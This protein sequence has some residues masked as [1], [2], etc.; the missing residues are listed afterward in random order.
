MALGEIFEI[1]LSRGSKPYFPEQPAGHRV[2]FGWCISAAT[3]ASCGVSLHRGVSEVPLAGDTQSRQWCLY[4]TFTT[5]WKECTPWLPVLRTPELWSIGRGHQGWTTLTKHDTLYMH[6]RLASLAVPGTV[7]IPRVM[8]QLYLLP[9]T[10]LHVSGTC[11]C[12]VR[13]YTLYTLHQIK[14][15]E[16]TN[17]KFISCIVACTSTWPLE[18][19]STWTNKYGLRHGFSMQC[20]WPVTQTCLHVVGWLFVVCISYKLIDRLLRLR[21]LY[22]RDREARYVMITGCGRG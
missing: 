17:L 10:A 6:M 2:S 5:V 8:F 20:V 15:K 14:D 1:P 11:V 12:C 22:V 13:V 18:A 7:S 16:S 19:G 4:T 21:Y 9:T 3:I